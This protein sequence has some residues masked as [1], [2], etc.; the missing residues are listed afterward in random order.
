M[1][2]A[3]ILSLN[4]FLHLQHIP[5]ASAIR[6]R[7]LTD[8]GEI[9]LLHLQS[10]L[11]DGNTSVGNNTVNRTESLVDLFEGRLDL[12][13]VS[14]ITLPSLDLDT[15]L[16]CEVGGYVVGICGRVED[17]C[18]VCGSSGESLGDCETDT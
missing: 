13:G 8:F 11:D 17:D 7:E 6:E 14:N 9:R 10:V 1:T 4:K 15:V 16:L 18:N 2:S 5:P 3:G 12:L